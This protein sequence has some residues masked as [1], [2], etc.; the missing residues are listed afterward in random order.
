MLFFVRSDILALLVN[1]LTSS[2]E[3]C[4]NITDNLQLPVQMQLSA[5]LKTFPGFFITFFDIPLNFDRFK[6]QI[7]LIA[8]VFLKLLTP[9]D[10][11]S[12]MYKRSCI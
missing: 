5:K 10:M 3:H 9:K 8:Q 7:S 11:F 12:Y 4:R 1:R 6:K 2:Y